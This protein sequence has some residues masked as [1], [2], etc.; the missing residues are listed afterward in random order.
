MR[1]IVCLPS[2]CL[3]ACLPVC[4]TMAPTT[5]CSDLTPLYAPLGTDIREETRNEGRGRKINVP[6]RDVGLSDRKPFFLLVLLHLPRIIT[7]LRHWVGRCDRVV[8]LPSTMAS[9]FEP[10]RPRTTASSTS[11]RCRRLQSSCL[12][13]DMGFGP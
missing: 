13:A 9:T 12:D 7:H 2:V 6:F 3:S 1:G 4:A 8:L 5:T 11:E 10:L